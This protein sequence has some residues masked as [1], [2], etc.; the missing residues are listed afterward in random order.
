MTIFKRFMEYQ[1]QNFVKFIFKLSNQYFIN[2]KVK[3][4]IAII[5]YVKGIVEYNRWT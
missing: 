2:I 5:N 4:I 1:R 3:Y